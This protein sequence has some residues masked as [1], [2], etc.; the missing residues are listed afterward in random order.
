MT[1]KSDEVKNL[2]ANIA[3]ESPELLTAT[4]NTILLE[5]YQRFERLEADYLKTRIRLVKLRDFVKAQLGAP[6]ESVEGA[7]APTMPPRGGVRLGADGQ[8][9]TDPAQLAAEEAMDAAAGTSSA[10]PAASAPRRGGTRVGA[11]GQPITDP[12]QLAAEEA[13]DAAMGLK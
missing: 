10:A 13:M 5:L 7:P 2:L 12:S 11:D 8:P 4:Q 1:M 3:N 6:A 9:I